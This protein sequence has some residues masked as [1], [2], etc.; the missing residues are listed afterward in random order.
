M[1]PHLWCDG[2][3]MGSVGAESADRSPWAIPSV[4]EPTEFEGS[5]A[6]ILSYLNPSIG[7]SRKNG[8]MA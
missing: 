4:D 5:E 3:R 2:M 6:P 7:Y 8:E 1:G